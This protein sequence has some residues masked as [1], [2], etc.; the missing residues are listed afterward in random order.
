MATTT[1]ITFQLNDNST[2]SMHK[3]ASVLM[4]TVRDLLE[5]VPSGSTIPLPLETLTPK[6]M[7]YVKNYCEHYANNE[8]EQTMF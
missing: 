2:F 3:N 5:D 8:N 4:K 6:I 1:V 7:E